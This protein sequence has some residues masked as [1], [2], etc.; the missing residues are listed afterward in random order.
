MSLVTLAFSKSERCRV[1]SKVSIVHAE[2]LAPSIRPPSGCGSNVGGG[3]RGSG[4]SGVTRFWNA[5]CIPTLKNAAAPKPPLYSGS[6][7]RDAST[8][9]TS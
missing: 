6:A 7:V 8:A 4:G 9:S 3:S 2:I 5:A 1:Y